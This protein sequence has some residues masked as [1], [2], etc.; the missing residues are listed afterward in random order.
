MLR[1]PGLVGQGT[2]PGQGAAVPC[3][4]PG[5]RF[6]GRG[7]CQGHLGHSCAAAL[8]W[9]GKEASG[10]GMIWR[11]CLGGLCRHRGSISAPFLSVAALKALEKDVEPSVC[12][13]ASQ[14]VL[15]LSPPRKRPAS[16]S[17][18]ALCCWPCKA[19]ER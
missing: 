5:K 1:W 8:S 2:E 14:T 16:G 10:A 19:R 13:L 18:R 3:P 7:T 4:P 11:G 12:S 9:P 6:R 17:T 15:I